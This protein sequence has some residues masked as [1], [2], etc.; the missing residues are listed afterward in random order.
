ML[1]VGTV[2]R[3]AHARRRAYI[4]SCEV[5]LDVDREDDKDNFVQV[6]PVSAS[7]VASYGPTERVCKPYLAIGRVSKCR[8]PLGHFT[9]SSCLTPVVTQ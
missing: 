5:G 6:R 2:G 7:N 9:D 4:F 8:F 3:G 1:T